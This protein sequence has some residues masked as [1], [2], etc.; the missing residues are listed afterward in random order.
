MRGTVNVAAGTLT[1]EPVGGSAPSPEFSSRILTQVYGDQGIT[2]R[3]YSTAVTVVNPSSPGKK[4]YSGAV[5]LRNL[6]SYPIGDEQGGAS[7]IDTMG[8]FVIFPTAPF[9]ASPSPCA[10]CTVRLVN[11]DGVG[12]FDAPNE[13]YF[14]WNDRVQAAGSGSDTTLTR[15][16]WIFEASTGVANFSFDVLVSAAW[17]Q[18]YESVWRVAYD[19][20]SLP[21]TQSEPRWRRIFGGNSTTASASGGALDIRTGAAGSYLTYLRLDS[22]APATSAF[23]EGRFRLNSSSSANLPYSGLMIDDNVR[24]I[25]VG[26]SRTSVGFINGALTGFLAGGTVAMTTSAYR[27]YQLRKFSADSAQIWVG[28]SRV[29]SRSYAQFD[30]STQASFPSFFA[31]GSIAQQNANSATYDYVNYVLGQATP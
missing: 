12:A 11:P 10:G 28:G 7:P 14:F 18:P 25:G 23:M 8:I 20:D 13:Q 5:G 16:T 30:A 3:L 22:L 17:P 2:V 15:R 31:F 6:L 4:T 19:G 29:L 1:F 27:T 9:V 21:D 26:V 24:T